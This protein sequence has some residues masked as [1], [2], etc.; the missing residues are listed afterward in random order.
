MLEE[1]LR[2][3]GAY[4]YNV[5]GERYMERYDAERM[6][7]STRDVV[8]RAG[9]LEIMEGRGTPDGGVL[10]DISHLGAEEVERRFPGMVERTR[11]IG[12]DLARG[13]VPVSPTAHFHMG[14]A[15]IDRDCQ[16]SIA[17]LLVAGEDAGGTHGANRLGGN[18]VAESTVFGARAGDRAAQIAAERGLRE[19][20]PS[21]VGRS[22]ERAFEPLCRDGGESPFE[23][24][25]ALKEVM[26]QSC[27]VVRDGERL[28]AAAEAI[29]DLTE[30]AEAVA[31]P[32]PAEVNYAWQEALDVRNQLGVAR[33]VVASA[34]HRE[35]SRGAHH[36]SDFPQRDDERWLRYVV[37]GLD[38]GGELRS[39][40]RPV[41][42]ERRGLASTA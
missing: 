20:E 15:I 6:E 28:R 5:E 30:R 40:T 19:P 24:T 34:L 22:V 25:R 9:Y 2:G 42:L 14:G 38:A 21:Q 26:W 31:V 4:L 29:E 16:T 41:E 3:A 37:V 8:S 39:S 17:G 27:G 18:G 36:R 12:A 32:G 13:P 11:Q 7:R 35:E 33:T 10:I 1:G 23:L